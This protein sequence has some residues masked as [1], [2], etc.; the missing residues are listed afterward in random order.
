MSLLIT[1]G[2]VSAYAGMITPVDESFITEEAIEIL[3]SNYILPVLGQEIFDSIMA[4]PENHETLMDIVKPYIAK[5][6]LY[7]NINLIVFDTPFPLNYPST[8]ASPENANEN[9][10]KFMTVELF[11]KELGVQCRIYN[12]ILTTYLINNK[13]SYPEFGTSG[14]RIAGF[15]V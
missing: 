7:H 6:F 9:K 10:W 8:E 1:P 4:F 11:A 12:N 14:R 3:Q 5:L 2:E 13:I 15:I